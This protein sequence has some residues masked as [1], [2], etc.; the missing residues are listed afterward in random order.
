MSYPDG[1][2]P[3]E[4]SAPLPMIPKDL[5]LTRDQYRSLSVREREAWS[6]RVAFFTKCNHCSDDNPCPFNAATRLP[7]RAA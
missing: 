7:A 6:R 4:Y 3:R 2:C 5:Q 1:F